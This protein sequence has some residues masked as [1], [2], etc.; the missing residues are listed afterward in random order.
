MYLEKGYDYTM[1]LEE[2][3]ED[4]FA[5]IVL[6]LVNN[7]SSHNTYKEIVDIKTIEGTGLLMVK[8]QKDIT[9]WLTQ[10]CDVPVVKEEIVLCYM[11]YQTADAFVGTGERVHNKE[12][13]KEVEETYD[14]FM[15][16]ENDV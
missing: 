13:I 5:K 12:L 14:L 7:K 10:I 1:D 16:G 9:E 4:Q 6:T 8:S 2:K 3:S 15:V 11:D